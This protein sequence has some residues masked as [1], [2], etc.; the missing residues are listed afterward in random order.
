MANAKEEL[1]KLLNRGVEIKSAFIWHGSDYDYNKEDN[2]YFILR[3]D[4]SVDDY[5]KFLDGLDFE[6]DSGYGSQ[7]LFGYVLFK[8]GTWLERHEYDGSEWWEYKKTPDIKAIMENKL[9]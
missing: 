3:E 8:D 9:Q 2:K 6:Y 1:I 7:E 4:Y 5:D